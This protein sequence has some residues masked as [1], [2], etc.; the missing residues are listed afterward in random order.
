MEDPYPHQWV[1]HPRTV[2]VPASHVED[3]PE[4]LSFR[5][6]VFAQIDVEP[7]GANRKGYRLYQP[8][9]EIEQFHRATII[10]LLTST[11]NS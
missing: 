11:R 3:T 1:K 8:K 10:V 9:K 6:T 7:T 5:V 4:R 2:D